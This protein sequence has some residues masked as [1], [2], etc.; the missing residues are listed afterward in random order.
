MRLLM[1]GNVGESL[2]PPYA[3]IPKR[4]LLIAGSMREAGHQVGLAFVYRHEHE[5][6]LG[7]G[8]TYFF[9]YDHAPT[10]LTKV[11]FILTH[12]L[13]NPYLYGCLVWAYVCAHR[14]LSREALVNAA[15]G[16]HLDSIVASFKP[17]LILS[18]AAII[19]TFM[20]AQIA[21]RRN[22]PIVFDTYAE[23][24]DRS[25]LKL[26][27]GEAHRTAYW[28]ELLT[29]PELVIAPSYYCGKGPAEFVSPEK[30]K[31]IYAGIEFE[32]YRDCPL[33]KEEARTRLGLPLDA[34]LVVAVGSLSPRKGHDHMIEAI[35][36]MDA[37]LNAQ[38]VIC[39]PGDATWLREL[40]KEYGIAN[41]SH[42][43]TGLSEEDLIALYRAV[44]VYCDAS[45]TPRACL[46]MSVTEAMAIGKPIVAYD[47]AGLP[48][49][50][51]DNKNGYLVPLDDIVALSQ[52]LTCVAKLSEAEYTRLSEESVRLAG[53]LVELGACTRQMMSA[54]EEVYQKAQ[55]K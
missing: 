18:E 10:K 19:R 39:G 48:E 2:P 42:F 34:F 20:A 53:E 31:V 24:H 7:A 49:I 3:G 16:V 37:S 15:H 44:D 54:L 12:A 11:G 50:V 26:R 36:M 21:V 43:F 27:G 46:G 33:T 51:H 4:A 28:K 22:I 17:D 47:T 25:I 32:K 29:I 55:R 13:R 30:V 9:D 40:T 14:F 1:T 5:D 41:R 35:S 8:G 6:D 45:N 38:A 52:T 23:V